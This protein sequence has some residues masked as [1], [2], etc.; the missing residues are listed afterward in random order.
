S[1]VVRAASGIGDDELLRAGRVKG[2]A[3]G[4]ST[5]CGE[6]GWSAQA[7]I[8]ANVIHIDQ[9][10]SLLGDQ[11]KS[12]GGVNLYLGGIGMGSAQRPGGPSDRM[13]PAAVI[14]MEACDVG[15]F[16]ARIGGIQD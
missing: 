4:Y 6:G 3:K 15:C 13:Q 10:G 8:V 16:R 11:Q 7:A 9:V 14:N 1:R 12:T 2:H 5:Y